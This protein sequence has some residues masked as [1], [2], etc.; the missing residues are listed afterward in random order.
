MIPAFVTEELWSESL[1]HKTILAAN[2]V[3]ESRRRINCWSPT[4]SRMAV[5]VNGKLRATITLPASARI[6]PR[7]KKP[8]WTN[9][10]S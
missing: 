1:G 6:N 3:A 5:Q 2:P 8:R 4:R 7:P 10:M 9:R